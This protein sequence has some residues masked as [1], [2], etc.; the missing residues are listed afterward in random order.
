VYDQA[1][2]TSRLD[3]EVAKKLRDVNLK[4][5]AISLAECQPAGFWQ[6]NDEKL[7]KLRELYELTDEELE[8]VTV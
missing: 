7:E 4:R 8:G 3:A 1:A 5:S 2:D 6:P